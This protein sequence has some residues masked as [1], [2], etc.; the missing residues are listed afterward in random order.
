MA[1]G[2]DDGEGLDGRPM[3]GPDDVGALGLAF[4]SLAKEM[5]IIKVRQL[6]LERVLQDSGINV[7]QAIERFEPDASFD[8]KLTEERKAFIAAVMEHL[9]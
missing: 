9:V 8:E 4:L 7:E 2:K 3:L 5:W 6:V 1:D